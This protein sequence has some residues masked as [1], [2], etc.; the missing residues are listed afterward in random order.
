MCAARSDALPG[1]VSARRIVYT[2]GLLVLFK[3]VFAWSWPQAGILAAIGLVIESETLS[4]PF[5]GVDS[6]HAG[7]ALG[8]AV[9]AL[10][11]YSFATRGQSG[12]AVV[13]GTVG[14]WL[15]LDAVYALR[16]GSRPSDD[17]ADPDLDSGELFLQTSVSHLLGRQL[18]DGPKTVPELADACDLTE[19][20]VRDVL[21]LMA[22]SGVAYRDGDDWKLDES[23]VGPW[24]FV[25]DNTRR[26]VA[27]L[28]RPFR[29]FVP[30]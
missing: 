11:G 10:G 28:L 8:G 2:L 30:T 6:R 7:V 9:L 21:E 24:P 17:E 25:R 3:Y 27:R 20:R 26:L 29:L 19:S 12:V 18:R 16:A 14:G 22:E 1:S 15:V 4:E 23:R 13:S 5:E